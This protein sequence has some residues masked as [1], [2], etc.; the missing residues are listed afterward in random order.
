MKLSVLFDWLVWLI[1]ESPKFVSNDVRF[2]DLYP[3]EEGVSMEL[4]VDWM[5]IEMHYSDLDE[6]PSIESILDWKFRDYN[7]MVCKYVN[8]GVIQLYE[9]VN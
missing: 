6:Y 5:S 9:E 3:D 1:F 7:D 2:P 4:G 8:K